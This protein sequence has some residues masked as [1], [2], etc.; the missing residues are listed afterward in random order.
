MIELIPRG[1]PLQARVRR[2]PTLRRQ[3]VGDSRLTAVQA[4]HQDSLSLAF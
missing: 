2:Q 4:D 1:L 3:A